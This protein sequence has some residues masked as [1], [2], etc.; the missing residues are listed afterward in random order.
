MARRF[1]T[2][3]VPCEGCGKTGAE[4]RRESRDSVCL[5]C[6]DD[7]KRYREI[8]KRTE[9][10][11]D[12][13]V[14]FRV[15]QHA[16]PYLSGND[17]YN[18][19]ISSLRELFTLLDTPEQDCKPKMEEVKHGNYYNDSFSI[20]RISDTT[21]WG[22]QAGAFHKTYFAIREDLAY[23]LSALITSMENY[24]DAALKQGKKEGANLL[25]RLGTED[26]LPDEFVKS[27]KK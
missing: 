5:H 22:A 1:Y 11:K 6:L 4:S 24:G 16:I 7:L 26:L 10:Q 27:V 23:A 12:A 8:R 21:P 14:Q 3:D 17:A 9:N 13:Y 25:K 2:G 15:I 20:Q 19:L 18:N